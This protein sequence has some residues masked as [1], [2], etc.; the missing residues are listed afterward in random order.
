[1]GAQVVQGQLI[2]LLYTSTIFSRNGSA[3]ESD[4]GNEGHQEHEEH[5]GHEDNEEEQDRQWPKPQGTGIQG[6]QREDI[7]WSHQGSAYQEQ[8]WKG[9]FQSCKCGRQECIQEHQRLDQGPSKGQEGVGH[10]RILRGGRKI[11]QGQGTLCQG[12]SCV[13]C[14]NIILLRLI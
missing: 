14:L 10:H 11:S 9:C 7:W 1:M 13:H 5:E 12:Q 2:S 4:E 8:E 3:H 6:K